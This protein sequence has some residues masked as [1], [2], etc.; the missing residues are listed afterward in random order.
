MMK[1]RLFTCL[2]LLGS[3]SLSACSITNVLPEPADANQ[4]YRLSPQSDATAPY[5]GVLQANGLT[6]RI[7][8]PNAPKALRGYDLLV[9]QDNNRLITIDQA[10]WAD[11]LPIL[12]QRSLIS[13]MDTRA[14][15]TGI[16]PTSGA[17]SAYRAHITIRNFEAKFDQGEGNAP[18]II[19]DYLV[20][21]SHAGSRNLIGTQSF[22]VENRA[23]SNR[24]SDI[25]RSKSAANYSAMK[26]I[27]DWTAL[28]LSQISG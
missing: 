4:I 28:S 16:L 12:V 15:L 26:D 19:V 24:V 13:H 27:S 8:R 3:L 18:K 21:L 11:A 1:L 2:A 25:V 6:V 7:D 5:N 23:S 17:R 9:S 14:D 10:Q 20:T 22:R